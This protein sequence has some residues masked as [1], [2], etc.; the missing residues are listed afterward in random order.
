MDDT[1]IGQSGSQSQRFSLDYRKT[2]QSSSTSSY[3]S[4]DIS[5]LGV[6][7]IPQ[8]VTKR[9]DAWLCHSC[10][11]ICVVIYCFCYA[12]WQCCVCNKYQSFESNR[13]YQIRCVIILGL[14]LYVRLSRILSSPRSKW[15]DFA[16]N[17]IPYENLLIVNL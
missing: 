7:G 14:K 2:C 11:V 9:H 17:T 15:T 8:P 6:E 13:R 4:F 12:W 16:R 5:C 10:D 1:D 3:Y